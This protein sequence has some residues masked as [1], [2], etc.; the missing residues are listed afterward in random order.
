MKPKKGKTANIEEEPE[1]SSNNELY[2]EI[3]NLTLSG[4]FKH[5]NIYINTGAPPQ[6]PPKPPGNP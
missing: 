3:E 5:C 4:T 6:P 1:E 2:Y